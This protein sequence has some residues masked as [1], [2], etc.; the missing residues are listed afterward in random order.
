MLLEHQ[1]PETPLEGIRIVLFLSVDGKEKLFI[2][3]S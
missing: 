3:G 2:T 1:N